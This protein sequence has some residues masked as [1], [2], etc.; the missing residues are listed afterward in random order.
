MGVLLRDGRP[1]DRDEI[2]IENFS[3]DVVELIKEIK[4]SNFRQWHEP[5]EKSACS[6][7]FRNRGEGDVDC[8]K[9]PTPF[10]AA[11][12]KIRFGRSL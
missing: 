12:S 4:A 1:V 6:V 5:I 3:Y 7:L 8:M 11:S 2:V 9:L 10:N